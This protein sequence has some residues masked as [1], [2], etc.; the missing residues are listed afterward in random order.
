LIKKNTGL[1]LKQRGIFSAKVENYNDFALKV[2]SLS[3]PSKVE[4]SFV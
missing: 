1:H 3:H 4:F 2:L